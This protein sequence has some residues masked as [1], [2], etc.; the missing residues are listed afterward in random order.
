MNRNSNHCV[1]STATR[2]NTFCNTCYVHTLQNISKDI[3]ASGATAP[4]ASYCPYLKLPKI[5]LKLKLSPLGSPQNP[6]QPALTSSLSPP[7]SLCFSQT[8]LLTAPPTCQAGS[9]P[10][11][12]ALVVPSAWDALPSNGAGSLFNPLSL[13]SV[14]FI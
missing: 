3:D 13:F 9:C 14:Q 1:T 6:T 7:H 12:F 11:A 4:W 8:G 5:F 10:R 2:N